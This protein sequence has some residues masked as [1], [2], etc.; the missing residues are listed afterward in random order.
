MDEKQFQAEQ[1]QWRKRVRINYFIIAVFALVAGVALGFNKERL[2]PFL[3]LEKADDMPDW[4]LLE[5]VY[6]KISEN[7]DGE[8][9]KSTLVE[10]SAKGL[11]AGLGDEHSVYMTKAEAQRFKED[12]TGEIGGGIG[13]EIGLR[14]GN[15]TIIR[16]LK[17]NPAARAGVRAGDV[18]IKVND[19][20]VAGQALEPVVMKIRGEPGTSVKLTLY[21]VGVDKPI[22]VSIKREVVNNPSV[23]LNYRDNIAV[24]TV[25]RFDEG[26]VG[27]MRKAVSE[28][29]QANAKG[30]ILDLRDN[31]GGV[32]TAAQ[33]MA[34]MWID[35]Q[36]VLTQKRFS[37]VVDTIYAPSGQAELKNI[38]TIVLINE[39][40]ASASE[41][42]A[43]A[44]R[45][46]GKARLV[47]IKTYGKGSVQELVNMAGGGQLKLT[48]AHWFTAKDATIEKEGIVP[49]IEVKLTD[50]DVRAGKDGQL[51]KAL[52]LLR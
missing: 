33:G 26:T 44:L 40:S 35:G 47:G 19:E 21:R 49:D 42:L 5:R 43:A 23:E 31:G 46:Y 11:V 39:N 9:D 25:Y 2:L 7:Y 38:P 16:P 48:V 45:D 41:I 6:K 27:L 3:M 24:V 10:S 34:G 12:L 30:V 51:D 13:A 17:D 20:E 28:L 8:I 29:K 50:E 18:I 37:E 52:E 22:E 15:P 4:S 36:V 14:D 32:L 1:K